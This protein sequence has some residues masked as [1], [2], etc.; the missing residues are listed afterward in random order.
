[1]GAGSARR[2]PDDTRPVLAGV[3]IRLEAGNPTLVIWTCGGVVSRK[4]V[5]YMPST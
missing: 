3:L 5:V 2:G 1:M 4:N